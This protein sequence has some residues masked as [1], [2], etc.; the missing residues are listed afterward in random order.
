MA[1]LSTLAGVID[2]FALP[3]GIT[4]ERAT[5]AYNDGFRSAGTPT[6]IPVAP[7]VVHALVGRELLILPEGDRTKEHIKV[8]TKVRL[9]TALEG[10]GEQPDV[11]LYTPEGEAV[12]RRYI[13]KISEDWIA[14][15]GHYRCI[16]V[17]TN[18]A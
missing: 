6:S 16:A 18:D 9:Q 4:I 3:G 17:R 11:I 15:S 2:S 12:E 14:Q 8:F 10:A 5:A 13:V 7:A 1:I